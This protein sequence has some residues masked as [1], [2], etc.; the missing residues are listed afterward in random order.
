LIWEKLKNARNPGISFV[1]V[2]LSLLES[3]LVGDGGRCNRICHANPSGAFQQTFL[4][5][6]LKKGETPF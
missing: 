5:I 3:D 6:F 2:D 4:L 1:P